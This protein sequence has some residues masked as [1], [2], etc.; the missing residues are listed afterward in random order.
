M[1]DFDEARVKFHWKI[2][3]FLLC[4]LKKNVSLESPSFYMGTLDRTEWHL[5]LYPLGKSD[6][7][8]ACDLYR[9]NDKGPGSVTVHCQFSIV[10]SEGYKEYEFKSTSQAYSRQQSSSHKLATLSELLE[11]KTVLLPSDTL[12]I[13]CRMS[14]EK[15]EAPAVPKATVA[16][17][18][19]VDC[20]YD[21][22]EDAPSCDI[23]EELYAMSSQQIVEI[24]RKMFPYIDEYYART[25]F[26][27]EKRSFSWPIRNLSLLKPEQ[28]VSVPL[29]CTS[30]MAPPFILSM[31]FKG[32]EETAQIEIRKLARKDIGTI[33]V[34]CQL[35]VFDIIKRREHVST[36]IAKHFDSPSQDEVW[37]VPTFF[38]KKEL[39]E[40]KVI[41]EDTLNL[42]C[43]FTISVGA[44][45]SVIEEYHFTTIPPEICPS[46]SE[47]GSMV[48][49]LQSFYIDKKLFDV[50]LKAKTKTL[51]AHKAV[52][53]S[54]S[55]VFSAM[56]EHDTA[57]KNTNMVNITDVDANTL[58]RMLS[59]MYTDSLENLDCRSSIKLYSAADKYQVISLKNKCSSFL[60]SN[61]A[62][63]NVF[64]I[65]VLADMHQDKELKMAAENY[66]YEPPYEAFFSGEFEKVIDSSSLLAR[67]TLRGWIN[68]LKLDIALNV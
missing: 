17:K 34:V 5:N 20:L 19:L 60:K 63:D 12:T 30:K 51:R 56:F 38:N 41:P 47:I 6:D 4:P 55:P 33:Y 29:A 21:G 1:E 65:L 39:K 22:K 23:P 58:E 2:E 64:N 59:F 26:G 61:L 25:R 45:P 54:R 46:I 9:E 3:N 28:K 8:V 66:L 15:K 44:E 68:K 13:C 42:F 36:Q 53:G 31:S 10:I 43:S 16:V 32:K 52:I 62:V 18:A 24:K 50:E 49:D 37:S 67:S 11:K 57:E 48:K 7:H 14:E 40:S 35:V 27:V